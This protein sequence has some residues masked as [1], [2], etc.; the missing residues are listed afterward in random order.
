M[1][2][3]KCKTCGEKTKRNGTTSSGARRWRRTSCGA[4]FTHRID[5]SAKQLDMFLGWLLSKKTQSDMKCSAATFRR[6]AL[7]FWRIWPLAP[8]AGE[9]HDVVFLDGIWLSRSLVVLIACTKKHVLAWYPVP[10]E[11]SDSWA[12]LMACIAPPLMAVSD[13]GSGFSKT[14]R[15]PWPGTRVQRCVF[16]AF[17]QVKRCTTSRPKLD[18]DKELYTIAKR[19]LKTRDA[20]GAALWLTEY[21]QWCSRWENFL[22]EFALEDG[23]RQYAHE[24][25]RKARRT[26]DKLVQEKALFTFVDTAEERGGA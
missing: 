14:V 24:G 22:R 20:D 6:R 7:R 12:A 11:C 18:C 1:N 13:G 19:L 4:S 21:A 3:P 26:L 2:N 5:N 8:Y 25:L 17:C 16:H 15:V 23:K 10:S 9:I